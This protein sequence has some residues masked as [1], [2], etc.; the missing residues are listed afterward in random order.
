M[1]RLQI[2]ESIL[3]KT[4]GRMVFLFDER[5]IL[6]PTEDDISKILEFIPEVKAI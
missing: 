2:L 6:K 3:G 5:C 4:I 1:E